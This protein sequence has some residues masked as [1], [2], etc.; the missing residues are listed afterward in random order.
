[1]GVRVYDSAAVAGDLTIDPAS[2]AMTGSNSGRS[3]RPM[4]A[5]YTTIAASDQGDS[6]CNLITYFNTTTG[7]NQALPTLC[8]TP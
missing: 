3:T 5:L 1:M 8:D 2:L 7:E 6:M 4:A